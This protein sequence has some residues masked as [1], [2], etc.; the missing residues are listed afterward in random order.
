MSKSGPTFL[1][2]QAW[3]LPE[4]ISPGACR[5]A[6]ELPSSVLGLPLT[7]LGWLGQKVGRGPST[8]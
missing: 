5:E 4:A 8:D 6:E 2:A 3:R 1:D 7:P